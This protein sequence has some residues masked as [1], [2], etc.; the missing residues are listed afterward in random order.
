[1]SK[2][3]LKIAMRSYFTQMQTHYLKEYSEVT[4]TIKYKTSG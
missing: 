3:I 4:F 2:L 1:M